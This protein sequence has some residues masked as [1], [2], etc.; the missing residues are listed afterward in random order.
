M[1]KKL[2]R[3]EPEPTPN[4]SKE[5]NRRQKVEGNYYSLL[6]THYSLLSRNYFRF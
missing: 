5:G 4:P 2:R 3:Q 1:S 6:I